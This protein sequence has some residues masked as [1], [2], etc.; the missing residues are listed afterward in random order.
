[1][2]S[3]RAFDQSLDG[4]YLTCRVESL[5]SVLI[6]QDSIM[7]RIRQRVRTGAGEI[8]P[9]INVQVAPKQINAT[10]GDLIHL[11]CT[12]QLS[13]HTLYMSD[14]LK[15]NPSFLQNNLINKK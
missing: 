14:R 15:V 7:I 2:A 11:H 13:S 5:E 8:D 12:L 4:A 9:D 1:M 6:A 3:I 10:I